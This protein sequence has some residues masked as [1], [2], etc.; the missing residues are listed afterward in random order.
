MEE[1]KVVDEPVK[2]MMNIIKELSQDSTEEKIDEAPLTEGKSPTNEE[3]LEEQICE[4]NYQDPDEVSH[5]K[6]P[7]TRLVSTFPLKEYEVV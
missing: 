4:E 7:N 2:H 1:K 5:A 3:M 6:D